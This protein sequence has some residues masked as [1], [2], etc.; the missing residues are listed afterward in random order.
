[1]RA[2]RQNFPAQQLSPYFTPPPKTAH[3]LAFCQKSF[4]RVRIV[5]CWLAGKTIST[6]SCSSNSEFE[7]NRAHA[8]TAGCRIVCC[9]SDVMSNRTDAKPRMGGRTLLSL[10]CERVACCVTDLAPIH[11]LNVSQ[12]FLTAVF[13]ATGLQRHPRACGSVTLVDLARNRGCCA[14]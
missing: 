11:F 10:T 6:Y 13:Y 8:K 2:C 5:T 3:K 12:Y 4:R 14:P 1:V 9:V 7:Y